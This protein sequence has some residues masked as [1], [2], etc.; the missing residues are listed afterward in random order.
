ME[1]TKDEPTKALLF[2]FSMLGTGPVGQR[3]VL[4]R[5][6]RKGIQPKWLFVEVWPPILT[7]DFPFVEEDRTFQHDVYWSDVPIIGRLYHRRWEAVGQL[8]AETLTPLL[9]YRETMLEH[10]APLLLPPLLRQWSDGGFEKCLQKHLDDFGWVDYELH[11]DPVHYERARRVYKRLFDNFSINDVSERAFHDMLEECRSYDIQVVFLL[12]PDHSLL[13]GWYA[14][15]QHRLM[16]YLRRLSAENHAPIVDAREWRPDEDI[17]D[18]T[19]LSAKGA[20][21][22]SVRFGR[23][24]YRPLLQ[25]RPLPKHVLLRDP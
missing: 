5:L 8:I 25:G 19:H 7:Q 1:Q 23:E 14:S 22:F 9:Q 3:M 20:R 13:R 18:C 16:P 15:M 6:L 17:P 10:Y 11:P 4:H 21:A 2:N 24:V 12:M